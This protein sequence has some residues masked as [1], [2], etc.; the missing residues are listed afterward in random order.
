VEK[1]HANNAQITIPAAL[2]EQ[3]VSPG[4]PQRFEQPQL[5][6][7]DG[8]P[9]SWPEQR[10]QPTQEIPVYL[11]SQM[12]RGMAVTVVRE[13]QQENAELAMKAEKYDKQ[14]QQSRDSYYRQKEA[15]P[16]GLRE[17]ARVRKS[18]QRARQKQEAQAQETGTAR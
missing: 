3:E 7:A 11:R 12:E 5:A 15:D 8:E 4:T 10:A 1:E 17:K 18:Q 14:K 6:S 16:A 2:Q 9:F 13:L